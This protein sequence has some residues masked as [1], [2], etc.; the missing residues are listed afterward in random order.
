MRSARSWLDHAAAA[1][2]VAAGLGA[3]GAFWAG[4]IAADSLRVAPTIQREIN[5]HADWGL[6]T[7]WTVGVVAALRLGFA[8]WDGRRR[9]ARGRRPALALF[10]LA[11]VAALGVVG[12]TADLGGGLVFRHGVAVVASGETD[13]AEAAEEVGEPGADAASRLRKAAD[14]SLTW[15]P[16]AGD[17]E[18]LG[19]IVTAAPGSSLAAVSVEEA[20]A[21]AE[22]LTLA[23]DG[24]SLLLL[25]GT[26]GDVQ[27]E[28]ELDLSGFEGTVGVAHH[29]TGTGDVGLLTVEAPAGRFALATFEDGEMRTL[30]EGT[31][32]L[33]DGPVALTVSAIGRHLRG[34]AGE[35]LVVHGHEPALPDG[36]CGLLLDGQGTVRVLS[37]RVVPVSH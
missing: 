24:R 8:L 15:R 20:E 32:S 16:A 11:G 1:T 27:V 7:V 34:L 30:G 36:A 21:G 10:V 31:R 5:T 26:V 2:W 9:D 33:P 14:G 29:A 17:A 13:M 4:R 37:L 23:V 25:P 12:R 6:Y 28:A 19:S 22:G 35:E 18:A 3:G